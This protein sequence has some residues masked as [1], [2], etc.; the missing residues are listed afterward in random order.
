MTSCMHS[1]GL[2]WL[3]CARYTKHAQVNWCTATNQNTQNAHKTRE[4][5]AKAELAMRFACFYT[6]RI[7]VTVQVFLRFAKVTEKKREK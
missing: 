7:C 5:K 2:T 3:I 6:K 4:S 1:D